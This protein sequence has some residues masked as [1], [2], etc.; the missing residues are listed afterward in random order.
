VE[1]VIQDAERVH[2]KSKIAVIAVLASL[3]AVVGALVLSSRGR[4]EADSLTISDLAYGL[5][6]LDGDGEYTIGDDTAL[7]WLLENSPEHVE[8]ALRSASVR[9][10]GG[11][12]L[13]SHLLSVA[14]P[15]TEERSA[16]SQESN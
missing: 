1:N 7:R 16:A 9:S 2:M 12:D 15:T 13:S 8:E 14:R 11:V 4:T 3:N 6:D 5:V 10:D